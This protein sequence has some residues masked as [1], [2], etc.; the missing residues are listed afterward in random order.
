MPESNNK[1][2]IR[3]HLHGTDMSVMVFQNEE[4]DYRTA[5]KIINDTV[6]TYY[7]VLG[8]R[9]KSDEE[10]LYAALLDITV[11]L[12]KESRRNDTAPYSDIL[13]RLTSE[14]EDALKK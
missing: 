4:E 13:S 6:N 9:G 5:A 11:R 1:L 3:L 2:R 10:I 8:D 7:K 14:I 12:C